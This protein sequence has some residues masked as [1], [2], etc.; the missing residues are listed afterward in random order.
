MILVS[1]AHILFMLLVFNRISITFRRMDESKRPHGYVP[2]PDLEGLQPLPY[3]PKRSKN[4]NSSNPRRY[5]KNHNSRREESQED[6][7]KVNGPVVR[8]SQPR[9]SNR[10]QRGPSDWHR[11][12]VNL[13]NW[14]NSG[15][16]I[17]HFINWIV[18][19]KLLCM[20]M[21]LFSPGGFILL[22]HCCTF[23]EEFKIFQCITAS[24]HFANSGYFVNEDPLVTMFG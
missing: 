10:F 18:V 15:E 8:N 14:R 24:F 5:F 19:Q 6:S 21:F 9:Q 16:L 22:L 13:E 4:L 7:P 11:V 2:E 1:N 3:E 17:Y 12:W 23:G 20:D